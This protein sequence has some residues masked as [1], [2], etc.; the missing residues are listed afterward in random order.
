MTIPPSTLDGIGAGT[1]AGKRMFIAGGGSGIGAALARMAAARGAKVAI[2]GRSQA[3]LD[4]VAAG[5]GGSL[6]AA[7]DLDLAHAEA[8]RRALSEY[9][10]YDYIATTAAHLTLKPFPALTDADIQG[11]LVSKIWGPVNLARAAVTHLKP[12]GSLLFF[13]DAAA[14]R[15]AMGAS[16]AGAL[17]LLLEGLAQSLALELKPR[18]VSLIWPG[19][20]R[21]P[22]WAGMSDADRQAW[23]STTASAQ[24]AGHIGQPDALRTWRTH[25]PTRLSQLEQVFGAA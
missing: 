12:D 24:P 6:L 4:A 10:P 1:L 9:G 18:R 17:D 11:M 14:Y 5:L 25:Y 21:S 7:Y 8:V 3:Q 2:A 16:M 20:V 19:L 15:S 22:I 13:S 23:Y